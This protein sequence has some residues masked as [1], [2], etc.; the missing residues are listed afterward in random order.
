[1]NLS[2]QSDK[3]TPKPTSREPKIALAC[4]RA[5]MDAVMDYVPIARRGNARAAATA[6]G[7]GYDCGR[8]IDL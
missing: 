2:A 7:V 5:M 1:M 4:H 6:I 3:N 8:R